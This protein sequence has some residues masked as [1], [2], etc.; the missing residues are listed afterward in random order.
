VSLAATALH[1]S[2][3]T[4]RNALRYCALHVVVARFAAVGSR[5]GIIRKE[6]TMKRILSCLGAL[7]V[8]GG[9]ALVMMGGANASSAVSAA[10]LPNL[11]VANG[12]VTLTHCRSYHHCHRECKRRWYGR[13]KCREYCHRC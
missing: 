3:R 12:D 11:S 10:T 4:Q 6:E 8:A 13:K 5:R 9:L 2:N 1:Q 7:A